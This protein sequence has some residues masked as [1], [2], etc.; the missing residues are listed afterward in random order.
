MVAIVAAYLMPAA[1][2]DRDADPP[3]IAAEPANADIPAE[4]SDTAGTGL[5][6]ATRR[7][8]TAGTVSPADQ[9]AVP[10]QL[11]KTTGGSAVN[12]KP[13]AYR[14]AQYDVYPDGYAGS[15]TC[16]SCHADRH[17]TYLKTH[18]SRSLS[19]V[20]QSGN[21]SFDHPASSRTYE[22]DVQPGQTLHR[23]WRYFGDPKRRVQTGQLPVCYQ[24]GSGAFAKGYLLTDGEYLIQS[25]VTWYAA[26]DEWNIAPGYES[27]TQFGM[28][29][30][31]DDQ[32]LFCHAGLVSQQ[33]DNPYRPVI[34]E[35]AIGCERCHGPGEEHS[36]LYRKI[37][38]GELSKQAAA[39]DSKIVNPSLLDRR[40][41]ESICAQCHIHGDV[42][43]DAPNRKLWDFRPGEDF[44]MTRVHL[45]RDQPG[46]ASGA[47]TGH[48]DQMWQSD[49]Y[50]KSE[51]LTC[52]TCHPSHQAEE[53][54]DRISW[55]RDQC[56]ECHQQHGCALGEQERSKKKNDC[57]TCHMP[58]VKTEVSHTSTTNH[59]IAV[60]EAGKP[61]GEV[62][63]TK[64]VLRRV[65][66]NLSL[67][68]ESQDRVDVLGQALWSIDEKDL[69]TKQ[70]VVLRDRVAELIS[71][72]KTDPRII[73]VIARLDRLAAERLT[74]D[75]ENQKQ[76]KQLWERAAAAARQAMRDELR[77]RRQREAAL[78]VLANYLMWDG[79]HVEAVDHW[80]ELTTIRRAAAD[81]YNLGL[82]LAR[83]KRLP[84]AE[85]A[86]RRSIAIDGTY[87]PPYRSL[88]I[89][90]R[91]IDPTRAQQMA[92][93]A[94]LL[95]AP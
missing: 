58:K 48:F 86:L 66:P 83:A 76:I 13:I 38:S 70:L 19:E 17:K 29:R 61:R 89:L 34:H 84:D 28:T 65:D 33:N 12:A 2:N 4:A 21:H 87:A 3:D 94:N 35:L 47:F 26:A 5:A 20:Q 49:C 82:C 22:V 6:T 50:T 60:Y 81:W 68:Q 9:R 42:V 1:L 27:A 55:R 74:D 93:M 52:M 41:A 37:E 73:S 90:Y 53:M 31:I 54:V 51:T 18:H 40:E 10:D 92:Q 44:A 7:S 36:D 46:E 71:N 39:S 85:K 79:R 25:P 57:I 16:K 72:G 15:K 69:E 14:F 32:C 67:D 24:M 30:M 8:G 59:L 80:T 62:G 75:P 95:S 63:P 91:A 77:P 45:K 64:A 88:S 56:N 78:E 43:V 11:A 23:E